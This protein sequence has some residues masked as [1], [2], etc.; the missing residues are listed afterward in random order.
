MT[1]ERTDCV[2]T[3]AKYA[4]RIVVFAP[5]LIGD[6]VMAT[7]TLRAL[8]AGHPGAEIAVVIRPN[9]APT[10]E[11]S[12]WIDRI[13]PF[14]HKAADPSHRT[15]PLLRRMRADR[16]DL[17]VL[18]PN[19]FRSALLARLG[20]ARR[21]VGYARGGR[22]VLLTDRLEPRRDAKGDY[23]PTP[24][25]EYYLALAKHLSCPVDSMRLEL[26]TT[27]RDELA[28]DRAWERLGF[29]SADPVVCLNT[30][31]AFGPAKSW[32]TGH[33]ATLARRLAE[34]PGVSV[35]VVC[36]PGERDAAREIVAKSA[37][38]RVASLADEPMS[39]GLSKACVKRSALMVTTDSGPRHFAAAFGVPVV[40]L[41]G[42]TH[43][44]WT[45][46]HHPHAIH[47][48]QP[49]P[50]GPC[51]KGTCPLGHHRCM[52]E[53]SPDAVFRAA[54]GLL[55]RSLAGRRNPR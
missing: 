48:Q 53:L 2:R 6:T 37:H 29:S 55:D 41:F 28:A 9:V 3:E 34:E 51:Q 35:L 32:P 50:C 33:F 13:I 31:G 21:R 45:R 5:N 16:F 54:V 24:I 20:G 38:P 15:G 4:M 47:M 52:I 39:L 14:H 42:P 18:L 11:A 7:P 23:I 22:G 19:S 17:A 27:D 46:T 40:S 25:V 43:I 36:G 44:A 8:R 26:F 10:L 49:V 30:G 1:D 12:P